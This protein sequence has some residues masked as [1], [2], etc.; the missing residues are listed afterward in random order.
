MTDV[1]LSV[2]DRVAIVTLDGAVNRNALD[3]AS[4]RELIAICDR[5]DADASIGAALIRG[6][7]GAF[8]SGADRSVLEHGG[9]D[10][11]EDSR[12]ED[13]GSIYAS[14]FRFGNLRVP[15]VAA[16]TGAAVGAGVNLLLAADVAVVAEDLRIITGFSRIGIHPGG[17]HFTLLDRL[18]GHG[19]AAALGLFDEEIS[20][21][22]AAE[23]GLAWTAVPSEQVED[24]ALGMA[25][26]VA[27]D[28]QLA[29]RATATMRSEIGPPGVSWDV[30]LE[31]ERA[32]QM[33]SLRRRSMRS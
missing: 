1:H 31:M 32:P 26:R 4:A 19:A 10:P 22:R 20:G 25:Q 27:A 16:A 12:Y 29:R 17:G 5:I 6:A 18:G 2:A 21:A 11:A 24:R 30:A 3:P 23:L 15:S 9:E 28:P 13:L 7:N 33:W 8:C 14:F